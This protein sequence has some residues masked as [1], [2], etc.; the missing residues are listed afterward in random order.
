LDEDWPTLLILSCDSRKPGVFII[1]NQAQ[2]LTLSKGRGRDMGRDMVVAI[3][4]VAPPEELVLEPISAKDV[5]SGLGEGF[6]MD[7]AVIEG[8]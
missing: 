4:D 3:E 1:Q 6:P 2:L 7:E 8:R 5:I